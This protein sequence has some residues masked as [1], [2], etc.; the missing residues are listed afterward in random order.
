LRRMFSVLAVTALVAAM[1]VASA[2]PAF[3]Q[4][5]PPGNPLKPQPSCK[6]AVSVV[7][8]GQKDEFIKFLMGIVDFGELRSCNLN[9][10]PQGGGPPS[11]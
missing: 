5:P 11:T 10:A 8:Q 3:A 4:E 9:A 6:N 7:T 1:I 2:L